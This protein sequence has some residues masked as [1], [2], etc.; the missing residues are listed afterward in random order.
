MPVFPL[1]KDA[2]CTRPSAAYLLVR[3]D[4]GSCPGQELRATEANVLS[5]PIMGDSLPSHQFVESVGFRT[6][7]L[8]SVC[9]GDQTLW[10]VSLIR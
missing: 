9:R 5:Y 10:R 7:K 1:K 2:E 4:I 6:Q 8:G 3:G